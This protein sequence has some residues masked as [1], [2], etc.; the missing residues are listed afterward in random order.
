MV[1]LAAGEPAFRGLCHEHGTSTQGAA[2]GTLG[3]HRRPAPL[4]G[5][6]LLRPA[7]RAPYEQGFDRFA[8]TLCQQ[9]Y[10]DGEGRP[11]IAPGVYFRMLFVGYFE[12]LDSQR[13][14]A[15]RCSDSLSLRAFLGTP[16]DE[17][18]PDHSSLTRIRQRLPLDV[19]ERVFV[20]VLQLAQDKKLLRGKTVAIDATTLEANAALKSIVRKDTGEA[21]KAYLKRLLL[22]QGVE[23][24]TDE[25]A[26]RFDRKRPKK[27]SNQEWQS[28]TDPDSRITKM[29]DSA[30]ASG[31]QGRACGGPGLGVRTGGHGSHRG[32]GRLS[33]VDREYSS[34]PGQPGVSSTATLLFLTDVRSSAAMIVFLDGCQVVSC[35]DRIGFLDIPCW[36][37]RG[38][39]TASRRAPP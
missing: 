31:V 39:L 23:H 13:A 34:G 28:P 27:G 35:N 32:S 4:A 15:W 5:P 18:T 37:V 21:Y 16:L 30:H 36:P 2:S 10:A 14:I 3:S 25:D 24:P 17:A 33:Y 6:R 11:S 1:L 22:E 8:E 19:H 9:Y 12:G 20:H 7:Q 38:V 26:R 29:K